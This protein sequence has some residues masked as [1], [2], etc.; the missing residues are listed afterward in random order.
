MTKK[1]NHN[2]ENLCANLLTDS[3]LTYLNTLSDKCTSITNLEYVNL[4]KYDMKIEEYIHIDYLAK[5]YDLKFDNNNMVIFNENLKFEDINKYALITWWICKVMVNHPLLGRFVDIK[6]TEFC[7]KKKTIYF[8]ELKIII[9]LSKKHEIIETKNVVI[10]LDLD[11][12]NICNNSVYLDTISKMFIKSMTESML[13]HNSNYSYEYMKIR[14]LQSYK[15]KKSES[16]TVEKRII[17]DNYI[18][19]LTDN[20]SVIWRLVEYLR[21][22]HISVGV[23]YPLSMNTIVDILNLYDYQNKIN[24]SIILELQLSNRLREAKKSIAENSD[25]YVTFLELLNILSI[26]KNN[27]YVEFLES[28]YYESVPIYKIIMKKMKRH[29]LRGY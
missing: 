9:R 7:L 14:L 18:D 13:Y 26:F 20:N 16:Y 11:D 1:K 25:I 15:K 19:D 12:I 29:S 28:F 2:K 21:V 4:I 6:M 8:P 22:I 17:Y 3:K 23:Q 5:Y 24:D 10:S 27:Q